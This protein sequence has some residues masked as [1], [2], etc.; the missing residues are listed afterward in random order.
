LPGGY[1]NVRFELPRDTARLHVPASALIFDRNGLYV[2][3]LD[4]DNRVVLKNVTI[5]RDN[6]STVEIAT[7]LDVA[8]RVIETPPDGVVA[9]SLV[10]VL[11]PTSSP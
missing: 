6:G 7:G 3:T 11:G 4:G 1:A 2:A 8:D 9:G 5:A 10:R